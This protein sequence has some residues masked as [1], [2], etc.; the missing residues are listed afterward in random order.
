M[1]ASSISSGVVRAG[2]N[3]FTSEPNTTIVSSRYQYSGRIP[4]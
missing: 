1:P 3:A 2:N 4:R